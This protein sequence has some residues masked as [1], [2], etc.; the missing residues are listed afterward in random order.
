MFYFWPEAA[1]LY[2]FTQIMQGGE[3][4]KNLALFGQ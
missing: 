4:Q 2:M 3:Q 1:Y